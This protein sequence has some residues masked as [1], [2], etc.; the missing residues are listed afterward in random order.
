MGPL[1]LAAVASS[2]YGVAVLVVRPVGAVRMRIR[3][4]FIL[5]WLAALLA[6]TITVQIAVQRERLASIGEWLVSLIV[7]AVIVA[8]GGRLGRG[9]IG[10]R[11]DAVER[12]A[13]SIGIGL[14]A[15]SA[16]TLALGLIGWLRFEVVLIVMVVIVAGVFS[17]RLWRLDVTAL[18][19]AWSVPSGL[20]RWA[21]VYCA[22][23]LAI[24]FLHALAPATAWDALVYHLKGP[25]LYLAAGR[26]G[27]PLDQP[28][29]GFPQFQEM[30]FLLAR[31]IGASNVALLHWVFA[32]ATVLL[33]YSEARHAWGESSGWIAAAIF[34][35]AQSIVLVAGQPYVDLTLAFH[36]MA[37][38]VCI[39][40]WHDGEGIGWLRLAGLF[41]GF[42][43]ATK[44]TAAPAVI[45]LALVVVWRCLSQREEG[46]AVGA[47][48]GI[49][50][51]LLQYGGV[52]AVAAAPWYLKNLIV[53]G[54]PVY[55][56]FFAAPYW[57]S[58]RAAW[59]SRFGSGLAF[60]A[61]LRLL[62]APLE[63]TIFGAEG[64]EPFGATIG[65][66]FLML[67][68]VG[69]CPL[70][71]A[72]RLHSGQ[73]SGIF[74]RYLPHRGWM[75]DALIVC[76]T[77][78]LG[79]LG[80][81]AASQLLVQTRLLFPVFP[82]L[83]VIA[84]GGFNALRQ[85]ESLSFGARRI[86][87]AVAGASLALTAFNLALE[88]G[89]SGVASVLSG[90]RSREDYLV[91]R[92]G[93]HALAMQSVNQ[94]P[95][96]SRVIFLWEP[97]SL[98]CKADCRP[99]ALLDRWWHDRQT[100]GTPEAIVQ[101]WREAGITHVLLWRAGYQ[102]IIEEGFDPISVEDQAALA[103]LL[104]SQLRL[105]RNFDGAY[106]LYAWRSAQ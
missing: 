71:F 19:R 52:A 47:R 43:I 94:L 27:Q 101:A 4:F 59:Y 88:F 31:L 51:C 1:V 14:G 21:A 18:R 84:A 2:L 29:L 45:G 100:L 89:A 15:L 54:N 8:G 98:Y 82:L 58:F 35:S 42:A 93:W 63:A 67:V 86:V 5:I 66:L 25:E 38:F 60:T 83:A 73:A 72:L 65:P 57:D 44:Y 22:F 81:I 104:D 105:I 20:S 95:A 64:R 102:F 70:R 48:V 36:I 24:A 55:P 61:P 16:M 96:D 68:P 41:T 74:E 85:S 91:D 87:L 50:R 90:G 28:Y 69:I 23:A 13:L 106:E 33:I 76:G 9:I 32:V 103:A 10:E 7:C 12:I 79:W 3:S 11:G 40:H 97:R 49:W 75:R 78:Y 62:T 37:T 39:R 99:D 26:I 77:A 56:F 53:T 34:L 17:A 46:M 80:M 6:A 92:L 30:L